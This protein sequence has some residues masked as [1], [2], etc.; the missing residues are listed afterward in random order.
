MNK[1][2][3][4]YVT[5]IFVSDHKSENLGRREGKKVGWGK[6]EEVGTRRRRGREQQYSVIKQVGLFTNY[7]SRRTNCTKDSIDLLFW[8]VVVTHLKGGFHT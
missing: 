3:E 5:D 7:I 6:G 1:T 8:S 4:Q 2:K